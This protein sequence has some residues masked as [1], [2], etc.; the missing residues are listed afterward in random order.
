M[1]TTSDFLRIGRKACLDR[2]SELP[3][4]MDDDEIKAAL[5]AADLLHEISSSLPPDVAARLYYY[6]RALE[7]A[8]A[9]EAIDKAYPPS[10]NPA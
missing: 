1:R 8:V 5:K 9:E 3:C 7:K 4:T 6:D 10:K 2:V